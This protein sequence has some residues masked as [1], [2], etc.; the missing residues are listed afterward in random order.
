MKALVAVLALA[1]SVAA[2]SAIHLYLTRPTPAPLPPVAT[3][4]QQPAP[5][6]AISAPQ[7]QQA[8][9]QNTD[10]VGRLAAAND[11]EVR[12]IGDG[13]VLHVRVDSGDFVERGQ[14]LVELDSPAL[15]ET[16]R[17][18]ETTLDL[19]KNELEA[20][21]QRRAGA[22]R[23]GS[24]RLRQ[25]SPAGESGDA[26]E[27]R[28]AAADEEQ[29]RTR[30]VQAEAAVRRARQALDN[31]QIIAPV[32]GCV[33]QRRV[34]VGDR[35][36]PGTSL[37]RIV[38]IATLTLV[39][40]LAEANSWR[41]VASEGREAL[42][43]VDALPD[44]QF[45][46]RIVRTSAGKDGVPNT[47]V[48]LEVANP[49]RLLKPGMSAR[50]RLGSDSYTEPSMAASV[51]RF[52]SSRPASRPADASRERTGLGDIF[53]SMKGL[54]TT[55]SI[56]A[57]AQTKELA[58]KR[59]AIQVT[60]DATVRYFDLL[61]RELTDLRLD[62]TSHHPVNLAKTAD[63]IDNLPILH[64]DEELVAFGSEA[65]QNLRMMGERRRSLSHSQGNNDVAVLD[66]VQIEN[67]A[68]RTQGLQ[69]IAVG[70]A[71]VRRKMTRKY[72]L[73][74]LAS[75]VRT[76]STSQKRHTTKR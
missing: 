15:A 50:V 1:T 32:S 30:V 7:P 47:A 17:Q 54:A 25:F 27:S 21:R 43:T 45:A 67:S 58:R 2:G 3:T 72:N 8:R 24:L 49:N 18:A 61:E 19:A 59:E 66:E 70:L 34:S 5:A 42:V 20:Q 74:F 12:A 60:V 63:Q 62:T 13:Y 68:V 28:V 10:L 56:A 48:T 44:R 75:N 46:G 23:R 76:A 57:D 6:N 53:A 37:L 29:A 41:S 11:L 22:A 51:R 38:D 65:A 40:D 35:I 36:A 9:L 52:E 31:S 71:N 69:K 14:T 55:L 33:S 64:V 4:V 16:V 73:E 39:L 26:N